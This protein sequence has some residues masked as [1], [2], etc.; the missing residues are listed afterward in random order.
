MNDL[1]RWNKI[2]ASNSLQP[3]NILRV[4]ERES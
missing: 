3:G 2:P 4:Y 1:Q